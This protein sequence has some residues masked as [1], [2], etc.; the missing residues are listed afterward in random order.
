MLYTLFS[1]PPSNHRNRPFSYKVVYIMVS[2]VRRR[3]SARVTISPISKSTTWGGGG[4]A[5]SVVQHSW[6]IGDRHVTA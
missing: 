2:A 6:A 1:L 3:D 4:A 5:L